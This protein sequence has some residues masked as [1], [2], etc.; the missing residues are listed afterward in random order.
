MIW[1]D[2]ENLPNTKTLAV[3]LLPEFHMNKCLFVIVI[4]LSVSKTPIVSKTYKFHHLPSIAYYIQHKSSPRIKHKVQKK[5][6]IKSE[7]TRA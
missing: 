6:S 4:L 1:L 5:L 2:S 7:N 3:F